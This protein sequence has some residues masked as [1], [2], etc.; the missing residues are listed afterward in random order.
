MSRLNSQVSSMCI[1][2]GTI[3]AI[4]ALQLYSPMVALLTQPGLYWFYGGA[5]AVATI[6][7][8]VAVTETKARP[9]G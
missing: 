7:S 6:F 4:G 2:T 3:F 1:T 5:S 9:V 8:L